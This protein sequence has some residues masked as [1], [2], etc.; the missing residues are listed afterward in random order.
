MRH[1]VTAALAAHADVPFTWRKGKSNR[2]RTLTADDLAV[3]LW[4]VE[5]TAGRGLNYGQLSYAFKAC[6]SAGCHRNKASAVLAALT[7]LGL[8]RQTG[9]YSTG[10]RGNVYEPVKRQPKEADDQEFL[11]GL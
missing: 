1:R 4:A 8:I 3:A 10:T 6:T 9:N 2:A 5:C 7:V 11:D